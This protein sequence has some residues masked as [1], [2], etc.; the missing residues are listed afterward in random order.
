MFQLLYMFFICVEADYIYNP[1]YYKYD[2]DK[3]KDKK[4]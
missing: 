2:K 1:L 3:E 4:E